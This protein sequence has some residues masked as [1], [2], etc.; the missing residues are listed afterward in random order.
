MI[1]AAVDCLESS[2]SLRDV[3]TPTVGP[4][5]VPFY[6][7]VAVDHSASMRGYFDW[8][9]EWQKVP[10]VQAQENSKPP[11]NSKIIQLLRQF[12]NQGELL[13]PG[14]VF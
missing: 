13:H 9:T 10:S 7:E 4:I 14:R 1:R 12:S 5:E 8:E 2:P 11:E 3:F 6:F